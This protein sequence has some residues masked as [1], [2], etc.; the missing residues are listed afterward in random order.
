MFQ[1]NTCNF[2]GA[3]IIWWNPK[4]GQAE[5]HPDT[6]RKM[7]FNPTEGLHKCMYKGQSEYFKPR[8][9]GEKILDYT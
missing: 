8:P 4:T 9:M 7:P 3:P 1:N 2:C 6:H 5:Y